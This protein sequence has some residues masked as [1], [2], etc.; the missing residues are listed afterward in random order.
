MST[1]SPLHEYDEN[2]LKGELINLR[3]IQSL[4]HNTQVPDS[5]HDTMQAQIDEVL[6]SLKYGFDDDEGAIN[7]P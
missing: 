4:L 7:Y 2:R 6:D 3:E 5:M 1:K